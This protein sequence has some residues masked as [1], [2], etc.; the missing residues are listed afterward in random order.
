VP[1]KFSTSAYIPTRLWLVKDVMVAE[2]PHVAIR[3]NFTY[4]ERGCASSV[5]H[6]K[7]LRREPIV[8]TH[9]GSRV[10]RSIDNGNVT[11]SS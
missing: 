8:S 7:Y 4:S 3:E 6:P 1:W 10:A 5:V 11:I 9:V 2:E